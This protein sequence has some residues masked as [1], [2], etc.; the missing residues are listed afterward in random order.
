MGTGASISP[1]KPADVAATPPSPI[2]ATNSMPTTASPSGGKGGA[3]GQNPNPYAPPA[4]QQ[5][6]YMPP[7][8]QSYYSQAFNSN[9]F[10]QPPGNAYARPPRFSPQS[11]MG[12]RPPMGEMQMSANYDNPQFDG[13]QRRGLGSL[14]GGYQQN[15]PQGQPTNMIDRLG[16]GSG[17]EE[18]GLSP[19]MFKK[20]SGPPQGWVRDPNYDPK[21]PHTMQAFMPGS[22]EAYRHAGYMPDPNAA[23]AGPNASMGLAG[24]MG[25]MQQ[26]SYLPEQKLPEIPSVYAQPGPRPRVLEGI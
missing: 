20:P 17:L 15:Y 12:A 25:G 26:P 19:S 18:G 14:R 9:P 3:G 21:A 22:Y 8:Q 6:M 23:A 2:G 5:Q 11:P 4:M 1:E 10:S 24:L 7:Q 16:T 13:F